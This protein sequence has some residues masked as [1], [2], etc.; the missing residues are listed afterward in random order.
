MKDRGIKKLIFAAFFLALGMVL[1][2]LTGQ[3]KEIG[4]SLL[5]MHLAVMLCGLICGPYF[6]FTVGMMLPFLRSTFF[7]MPPI[8]PNAVWMAFELATYGLVIGIMWM[9]FK[10]K[11]TGKLYI[12]LV[13]SMISGRIVW[14]ITKAILMG[15]GGKFFTP[16][17]FVTGGFIDAI[18][19]IILQLVL[20]PSIIKIIE[21]VNKTSMKTERR[22][23]K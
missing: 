6:G 7:G 4:D 2:L 5:P 19:G 10:K 17:A 12:S 13:S 16:L 14:G 18:P 23:L 22:E 9:A 11:T 20:I 21:K 1:P 8:Y 3:I 15:I